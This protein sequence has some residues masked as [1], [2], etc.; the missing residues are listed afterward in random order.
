MHVKNIC[1]LRLFLEACICSHC[2]FN[3]RDEKLPLKHAQKNESE[4]A[5]T[6]TGKRI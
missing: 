2:A 4:L 1:V 3:W 5:K 6:V